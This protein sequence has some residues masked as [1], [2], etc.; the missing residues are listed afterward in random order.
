MNDERFNFE[1]RERRERITSKIRLNF[2]RHG[3]KEINEEKTDQEIELTLKGR[4]QALGKSEGADISQSIAFGSPRNRA[5][6]TAG[7]VMGGGL[8]EVTGDE[9][10]DQLRAKLDKELKIG[11]KIGVH[12]KLD[13]EI[14]LT[15]EF[16]KKAG[17]SF[18]SGRWLKFLVEESDALAQDLGDVGAETYKKYASHV[19]KI[20]KKHL[21]GANRWDKLV[22]DESKNYKDTLK[23]LFVTHQG[24]AESFLARVIE[25]T[26]GKV[27]RDV[28]VQSLNNQGF[29]FT[30]GF[31][32]KI[33]TINGQRQEVRISFKKEK[34]GKILYK[35]DEIVPSEVI[36]S[37]IID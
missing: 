4:K 11:S 3:E 26:K 12:K 33:E 14:D 29:D 15:T 9:G 32:I 31:E 27:E 30:E 20:V 36:D 13:F 21:I 16:G 5:Q 23:R 18:G 10:L 6:Q 8:E 19:A 35:Y 28:F 24:V 2:L 1:R 17:E 25:K 37:L 34:D 7:F 22:Q